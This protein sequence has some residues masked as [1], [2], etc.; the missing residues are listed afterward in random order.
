VDIS[1]VL[2]RHTLKELNLQDNPLDAEFQTSLANVNNLEIH[3]GESDP[4]GKEL[5]ELE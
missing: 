1:A 4:L 2:N 3:I 5:D